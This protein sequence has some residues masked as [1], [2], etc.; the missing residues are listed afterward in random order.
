MLMSGGEELQIGGTAKRSGIAVVTGRT[1]KSGRMRL[2]GLEVG[3]R[4]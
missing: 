1:E 4:V 3:D 2:E